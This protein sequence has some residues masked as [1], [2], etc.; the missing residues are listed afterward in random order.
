MYVGG[1]RRWVPLFFVHKFGLDKLMQFSIGQQFQNDRNA[2]ERCARSGPKKP[3][4]T[5]NKGD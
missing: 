4:K 3:T 5:Y 1:N 2:T